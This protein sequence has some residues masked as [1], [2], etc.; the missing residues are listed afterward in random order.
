MKNNLKEEF[1]M[2]QEDKITKEVNV[3]G[4]VIIKI[5]KEGTHSVLLIQRSPTDHWKLVWE[6]PRGKCDKGD[7]NKLHSCLKRE[8]KEETGLDIRILNYIDKYEYIADQGTRRSTQ[9][10][11][12]C[13]MDPPNQKVKLSKEHSDYKWVQ[14]LGEVEILVPSE[15]KKTISKVLNPEQQIVIYPSTKEAIKE[16]QDRWKQYV[17]T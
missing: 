16:T 17:K 10:N 2:G 7:K 15:M 5:N 14:S 13:K 6:F 12:L 4:A 8:V 11:Y 3:A 9:Y 1:L